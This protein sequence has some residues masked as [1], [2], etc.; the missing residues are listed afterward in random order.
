MGVNNGTPIGVTYATGK[1]GQ[2]FSFDGISGSVVVPDSASL[3][4]A[5]NWT[6]QA[7]IYPTGLGGPGGG[8][9]IVSKVGGS[10]GNNGYQFAFA[11]S[12]TLNCIFNAPGEPWP[13]NWVDGGVIDLNTWSHV[14]CT[15]DN[16]TLRVYVNGGL[17]GSTQ[18]GPKSVV[19]SSSQLRISG[20]DNGN[21]FFPGLIDEPAIYNRALTDLEI[22]AI[23]NA[24][25][26]GVC[27][28]QDI[29]V[30]PAS[31]FNFGSV[32]VGSSAAQIFTV[33]NTGTAELSITGITLSADGN[34]TLDLNA[35]ASPC[36]ASYP[37]ALAIGASCTANVTFHPSSAGQ[38]NGTLTV[39]SD[40]PDTPSTSVAIS[41]VGLAQYT[42]TT[43]VSPGGWG[44]ISPGGGVYD[45]GTSVQL[46]ASS[47]HSLP[48]LL[49]PLARGPERIP[50][51]R[52]FSQWMPN[53][54]VTAVFVGGVDLYT[55]ISPVGGG[56][57]DFSPAR[58]NSLGDPW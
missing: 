41:G 47:F 4:L 36:G 38:K 50:T 15:Y 29:A 10:G 34:Y 46:S 8:G 22:Q 23:Y 20:D 31:P 32:N 33:S 39:N 43:A 27:A 49:R 1:V 3:D 16:D 19:N 58:C 37:K 56:S 30:S 17:V 7:W 55:D 42:L 18:V 6:L 44:S 9:G 11:N 24:G 2:A 14:A 40:D 25:S 35:G 53:K 57:I 12:G 13:Q 45:Q 52:K 51:P 48:I 28:A 5:S 26:G 21:V 54:N